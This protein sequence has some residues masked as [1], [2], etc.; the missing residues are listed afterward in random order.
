VSGELTAE[1]RTV[2][3]GLIEAH[4]PA[5][6]VCD[7]CELGNGMRVGQHL[8]LSL[9][10]FV[11]PDSGWNP[12]IVGQEAVGGAGIVGTPAVGSRLGETTVA[13]N[14]RVG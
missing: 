6:T 4:R 5:H 11:G 3:E 9:T 2:V 12:L 13:G 1:Q 10:A 7:V 14:V 8:R